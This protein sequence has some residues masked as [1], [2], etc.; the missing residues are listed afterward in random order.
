MREGDEEHI[1]AEWPGGT[2]DRRHR[3]TGII[4]RTRPNGE[5]VQVDPD[6][7]ALDTPPMS[8][9]SPLEMNRPNAAE[10]ETQEKK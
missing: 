7:R 9:G 2:L 4:L 5:V 10:K 8:R 1:W 3:K 6:K